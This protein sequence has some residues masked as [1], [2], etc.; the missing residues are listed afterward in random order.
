MKRKKDITSYY[1]A[2]LISMRP[3]LKLT[4]AVQ[5]CAFNTCSWK[6]NNE[7]PKSMLLPIKSASKI[8]EHDGI[9]VLPDDNN[10]E[11]TLYQQSNGTGICENQYLGTN[12]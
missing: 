3:L 2:G 11:I 1:T 12:L 10:P 5:F 4:L 9:V 7:A 8:I 6:F